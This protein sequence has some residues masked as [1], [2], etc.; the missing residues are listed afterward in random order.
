MDLR[1]QVWKIVLGAA[2]LAG[3]A[4]DVWTPLGYQGVASAGLNAL[5]VAGFS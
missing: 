4:Y 1:R 5:A 2:V 3:G